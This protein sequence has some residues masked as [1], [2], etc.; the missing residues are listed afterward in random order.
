MITKLNRMFTQIFKQKLCP[1]LAFRHFKQCLTANDY[2]II[3]VI[4]CAL[5]I[6]LVLNKAD[7][8]DNFQA[9]Q[10]TAIQN[11]AQDNARFRLEAF[12][13]EKLIVS[14]LNG[15]IIADGRLKTICMLNAAGECK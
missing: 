12:K 5:L 10:A 7:E 6:A 2:F 8:I 14:M 15:A 4:I 11:Y 13:T 1:R 3:V 9:K